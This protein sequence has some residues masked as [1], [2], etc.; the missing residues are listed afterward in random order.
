MAQSSRIEPF[1]TLVLVALAAGCAVDARRDDDPPVFTGLETAVAIAPGTA[2]LS[3][4]EASDRSRP[5]TYRVWV[6]GSAGAEPFGAAPVAET[7]DLSVRIA[8]LP[9]GA[10]SYFVVRARDA[11]GNEDDNV[12]EKGVL[13][14]ENRLSRVGSYAEP[15]AS[16][17]A[18]HETRDLV[19]LGAFDTSP[20]VRAWLF[21]VS[22]PSRPALVQ[23]IYGEGRST[24]VE[25]RGD[26]LWVAT[27]HDP[28]GHGAYAYDI[29][30]AGAPIMLGA[31]TGP[32][33][34]QCHT[35]WL[36]GDMLYCASSDDGKVHLVDVTDP[37]APQP[38]GSVGSPIGWIHDMYVSGD[39]AVACFLWG[40]W[41]FLDVSDPMNPALAQQVPYAGAMTHN[42]WPSA[43]GG[44]LFTTDE[45]AGGH[46]R[47]WDISDR[48]AVVQ[49]AEHF[50]SNGADPPAIVH[51]VR[52]LGDLAFV[53][54]YEDG[55][56][57]LDVSDPTRPLLI[58]WYDTFPGPTAGWY[59]GAWSAAPKLPYVFVSDF[60][61]GLFVLEL[62]D[63]SR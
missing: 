1:L 41:A 18:V 10:V 29:S 49:V 13:F 47:V 8:G 39:L 56:Q 63:S 40:G 37:A 36:D 3:W 58:G 28:D 38:R 22:D 35:L 42:A 46:L 34:G 53:A 5:V 45:T 59:A 51:N 30:D 21:D 20:Q 55:V 48:D 62:E 32:G 19:A 52:V 60:S 12:V 54:W 2:E 23:T 43:D 44:Y 33:L 9:V 17:I 4:S 14:A 50:S 15:T 26:V 57:V 24:D 61:A 11:R 16:D 31:L 6:A 27:E 7:R 25:I